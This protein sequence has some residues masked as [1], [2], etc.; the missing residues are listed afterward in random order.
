MLTRGSLICNQG[1]CYLSLLG[2][3]RFERA[4]DDSDRDMPGKPPITLNR[5]TKPLN[6]ISIVHTQDDEYEKSGSY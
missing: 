5:W 1:N 6:S 3:G 2:H 4:F